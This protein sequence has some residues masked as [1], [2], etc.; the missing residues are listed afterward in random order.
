MEIDPKRK[1]RLWRFA[2]E[3]LR[4]DGIGERQINAFTALEDCVAH[5]DKPDF[6]ASGRAGLESPDKETFEEVFWDLFL[7]KILTITQLPDPFTRRPAYGDFPLFR[8]H[9]E[10]MEN[11]A[12]QL[13]KCQG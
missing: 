9:S 12:E 13:R 3:V 2:L 5:M 6:S 7:A 10:G 8:L 1:L 11:I 4:N